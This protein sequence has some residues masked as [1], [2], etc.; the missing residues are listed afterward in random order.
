[1]VIVVRKLCTDY[2]NNRDFDVPVFQIYNL[3]DRTEHLFL[4]I[5]A[6]NSY[7]I[8]HIASPDSLEKCCQNFTLETKQT[9]RTP[10]RG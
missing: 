6:T 2:D 5:L 4:Q 3:T 9:G 10:H 1:M 8:L 7:F